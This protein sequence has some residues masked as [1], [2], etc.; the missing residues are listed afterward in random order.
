MNILYP[1]ILFCLICHAFASKKRKVAGIYKQKIPTPIQMEDLIT[2][3]REA[4]QF[5]QAVEEGNM[6]YAVSVFN[7]GNDDLRRYSANYMAK[8][9][10]SKLIELIKNA[11]D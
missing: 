7:A 6:N 10:S 8:L 3:S 9:G 1:A 2:N 4:R 11:K 5:R